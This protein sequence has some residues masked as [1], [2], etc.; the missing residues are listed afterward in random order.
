MEAINV[1]TDGLETEAESIERAVELLDQLVYI[2]DGGRGVTLGEYG[3]T[4]ILALLMDRSY[5]VK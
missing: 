3:A 4:T 2:A 5:R 1:G